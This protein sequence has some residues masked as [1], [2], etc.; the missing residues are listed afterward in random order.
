MAQARGR[1]GWAPQILTM[2]PTIG[3]KTI[4]IHH[5]LRSMSGSRR[6]VTAQLGGNKPN[7][8]NPENTPELVP[9]ITVSRI[10]A[11]IATNTPKRIQIPI[12]R[13]TLDRGKSRIR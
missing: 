13:P 4:N 2:A 1:S 10:P 3:T 7:E 11:T 8:L 6:T 9:K 12:L 5:P